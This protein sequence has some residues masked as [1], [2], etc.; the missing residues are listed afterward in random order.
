MQSQ[1]WE[2]L[3]GDHPEQVLGNGQAVTAKMLPGPWLRWVLY[4]TEFCSQAVA[5]NS[6][7]SWFLLSVTPMVMVQ[8]VKWLK[9]RTPS[10]SHPCTAPTAWIPSLKPFTFWL[11]ICAQVTCCWTQSAG[12]CSGCSR[13][14][15][16]MVLPRAHDASGKGQL[17]SSNGPSALETWRAACMSPSCPVQVGAKG[18]RVSGQPCSPATHGRSGSQRHSAWWGGRAETVEKRR[19]DRVS[20]LTLTMSQQKTGFYSRGNFFLQLKPHIRPHDAS[21]CNGE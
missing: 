8:G 12:C 19:K 21:Q 3:P 1:V 10:V 6:L 2:L 18:V 16:P 20:L 4:F 5:E 11:G 7:G 9:S 17:T 15:K 13:G 14:C